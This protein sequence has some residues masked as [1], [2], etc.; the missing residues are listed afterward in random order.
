MTVWVTA[1]LMV[2]GSAFCLLAAVGLVR[3]PDLFTRMQ[4][5]AKGGTL[6]AGLLALATAV[7]FGDLGTATKA[8]L[9]ILFLALTTPVAAHTI[10]RAAYFAKVPLWRGTV[11]D[12]LQ[13]HLEAD[14]ERAGREDGNA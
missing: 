12:D 8:G 6:G 4:A 14:R 9:V 3:L 5:A 13:A 11:Q 2:A 1:L 7:H 10:A